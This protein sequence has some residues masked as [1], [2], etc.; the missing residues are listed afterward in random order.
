M[1]SLKIMS[2]TTDTRAKSRI[3][4]KIRKKLTPDAF[5][6]LISLFF[7]RFPSENKVASSIE[8][9]IMYTNHSGIRQ[10][11]YFSGRMTPGLYF[12]S[13]SSL[14][15]NSDIVIMHINDSTTNTNGLMNSLSTYF[16]NIR[17]I[18]CLRFT[19]V[20]LWWFGVKN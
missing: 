14:S 1:N 20:A 18:F 9:G 11:K 4:E 3:G 19:S 8:S 15:K 17:I 13:V 5:I 12:I 6:A 2:V 7:E 10:K 16:V